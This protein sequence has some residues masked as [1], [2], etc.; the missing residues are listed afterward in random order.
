[1]VAHAASIRPLPQPARRA[2][3]AARALGCATRPPQREARQ[4]GGPNR[5]PHLCHDAPGKLRD[6]LLRT[7]GAPVPRHVDVVAAAGRFREEPDGQGK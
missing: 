3:P 7:L 4:S 6:V 5:S 1:M 2:V